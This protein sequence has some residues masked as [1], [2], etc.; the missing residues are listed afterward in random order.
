MG[1]GVEGGGGVGA[2][3]AVSGEG[4]GGAENWEMASAQGEVGEGW[5]IDT[6]GV[7]RCGVGVVA[8]GVGGVSAAG[9]ASGSGGRR[10]AS[11]VRGGKREGEGEGKGVGRGGGEERNRGEGVVEIQSGEEEGGKEEREGVIER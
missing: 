10:G 8:G 5:A 7:V 11:E 3:Q 9:T 2:A 4:R 6:A 1:V